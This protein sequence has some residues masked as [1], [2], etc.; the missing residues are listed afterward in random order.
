MGTFVQLRSKIKQKYGSLILNEAT[1]TVAIGVLIAMVIAIHLY[2]LTSSPIVFIDEPWYANA[3][4]NLLKTGDNFDTMHTGT[5]DQYGLEWVRWGLLGNV[6]WAV[7]FSLFGLGLFQARLV[8]WFFGILLVIIIYLVG[9]QAY[10]KVTGILAALLLSL[11]PPFYQAS[12][13][14]RPDIMLAAVGMLSY[15]IAV[16]AFKKERWY[17]HVLAG[18]S[19][20]LALDIHQ[21]AILY[22]MG[23]A[24]LYIYT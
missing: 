19:I 7:S 1:L 15:L 3:A 4:W 2:F 11:S 9:H 14:A 10:G 8:S 12:H 5:L 24:A 21:N 20:G 13:Y 6:P 17:L 22:M 18:L 16:T 23:I